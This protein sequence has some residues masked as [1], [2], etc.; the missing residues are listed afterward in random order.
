MSATFSNSTEY[1]IWETRWCE[2]CT[3]DADWRATGTGTSCEVLMTALGGDA[4]TEW[5]RD[6]T[7]SI[8]CSEF[9]A[10]TG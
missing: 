4:P 10:V 7:G 9:H 1:E 8:V 6:D 3:H 5:D 2:R